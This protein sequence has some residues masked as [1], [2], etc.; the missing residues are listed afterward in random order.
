MQSF[1]TRQIEIIYE[2]DD[3]LFERIKSGDQFAIK[4]LFRRYYSSLCRLTHRFVYSK[5]DVEDI[6]EG[7]FEEIWLKRESLVLN[8]SI[9]PYLF[10][11][12]RNQ[13]FNFLKNK[14]RQPI[15]VIDDDLELL[16]YS[17]PVQDMIEKD[18]AAAISEAIE[19][20]PQ[21]CKLVF[22]L[23]RQDG[24]S[25]SEIAGVLNISERTVENQIVRALKLLRKDLKDFL[26]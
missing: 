10:K 4:E 5:G 26:M 13:A 12:A 19:N 14:R 9:K 17:D 8:Q 11:A 25:Y 15:T 20:L 24:L 6:V 2:S 1:R 22:T 3:R 18:L 23:N 7:V 21:K 16:S